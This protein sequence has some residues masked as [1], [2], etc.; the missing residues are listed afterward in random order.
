MKSYY[1]S[2]LLQEIKALEATSSSQQALL[3]AIPDIVMKVNVDKVYTRKNQ[4]AYDFFREDVIGKQAAQYF[5]GEQE[6]DDAWQFE[7]RDNGIGIE[8]KY[9]ERIFQIFQRLYG[10]NDFPAPVLV[11]RSPR[12]LSK[13]MAGV[14]GSSLKRGRVPDSIS[15]FRIPQWRQNSGKK[16]N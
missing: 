10:R 5:E 6:L 2:E 3:A 16:N 9:F 11:S 12:K 13:T 8:A 15:P 7:V 4:A 1:E 14:S